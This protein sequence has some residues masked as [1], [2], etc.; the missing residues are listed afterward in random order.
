MEKAWNFLNGKKRGIALVLA[1]LMGWAWK[2]EVL[3][4]MYLALGNV[5]VDIL[6][7]GAIAHAM[8]KKKDAVEAEEQ[9]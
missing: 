9:G 8:K 5:L 7:V 2:Y 1:A 4:E 3:P 6:G